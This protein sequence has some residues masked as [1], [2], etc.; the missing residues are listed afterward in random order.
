MQGSLTVLAPL[1]DWNFTF[2]QAFDELDIEDAC[3]TFQPVFLY[4]SVKKRFLASESQG[5]KELQARTSLSKII[6]TAIL[7]GPR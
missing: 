6:L 4:G 1:I 5:L 7:Y 3:F 2:E